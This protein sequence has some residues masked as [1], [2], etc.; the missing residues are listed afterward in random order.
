MLG[1]AHGSVL[2]LGS[3][4]ALFVE[5][6]LSWFDGPFELV[7]DLV[8]GPR[9]RGWISTAMEHA[10]GRRS[11]LVHGKR[12]IG[13]ATLAQV[14]VKGAAADATIRTVD[15]GAAGTEEVLRGAD[16]G[17]ATVW[18]VLHVDRLSRQAQSD[19]VRS[20]R[21]NT[22]SML[23]GTVVGAPEDAQAEGRIGASLLT[24][25]EGRTVEVPG[26]EQRREDI[27]AIALALC[28]RAGIARTEASLDVMEALAR[29]GWPGGVS[30]M[31]AVMKHAFH[32]GTCGRVAA[33]QLRRGIPRPTAKMPLPLQEADPD[34]ARAR[35]R[36]ALDR[37][38][39]TVAVAARE[40][41]MS[42]QSFYRELRR[43]EMDGGRRPD[44]FDG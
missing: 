18:V 23:V 16:A 9:Q 44:S 1:I 26:L 7:G 30:E 41:R 38:S 34:L 33:Q 12:G 24:L 5:R 17:R 10:H 35:L 4:L 29:G 22:G 19:L 6:D 28:E 15:A 14:V 13:K 8:V 21:R 31:Q 37:A 27:P 39:G 42:R 25:V 32:D 20:V 40:L 11:F 3:V 2:R 43:L 36:R